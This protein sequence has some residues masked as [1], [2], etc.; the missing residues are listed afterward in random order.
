[1][2]ATQCL[3]IALVLTVLSMC[4]VPAVQAG[5]VALQRT[6]VEGYVKTNGVRLQ[7]LDWGGSG[8]ALILIHGLADTPHVFDDLAPAF[9]SRFHVIAYARR[10]SGNSDLTGPFDITT[11]T[12]DLR[13]LMDALGI[14]QANLVG[15]SAGGD[16]ITEMAAKYPKRVR[17]LVYLDGAYD[18]SDPDFKAFIQALPPRSFDPPAGAMVSLDAFRSNLKATT[19][20]DLDDM[21]RIEANFRDK[22]IIESDG[23]VTYRTPKELLD[24]LYS[25]LWSNTPR[26][27]ARI[28]SAALVIYAEDLYDLHIA[29]A[30]RREEL[31]AL[32]QKYWK[33]FQTESMEH[34][35]RDLPHVEIAHVPGAHSSFFMTDRP[36]VVELMRRFLTLPPNAPQDKER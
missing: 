11:L 8:P 2:K 6:A 7:Y 29:D 3:A 24:A 36:Q 12:E 18:L 21:G 27:Y 35:R 26:D 32:Q 10:G 20:P 34:I 25:A 22:V 23:S 33:P 1:M 9:T 15:Y 17:R 28:H 30:R 16:E 19:Y 14:A 31:R 5:T 4:T 13:G